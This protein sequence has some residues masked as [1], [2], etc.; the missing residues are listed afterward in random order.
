MTQRNK[1]LDAYSFF[2]NMCNDFS[3]QIINNTATFYVE[4]DGWLFC[5]V[6]IP[7]PRVYSGCTHI[8]D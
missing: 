1:F 7:L 2:L 5:L 3:Y 4:V 8:S 6:S